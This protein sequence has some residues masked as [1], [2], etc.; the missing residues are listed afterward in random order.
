[1]PS[2]CR[3]IDDV[4]FSSKR[5]RIHKKEGEK[6]LGAFVRWIEDEANGWC[7]AGLCL[8]GK[9]RGHIKG[10]SVRLLEETDEFVEVSFST[11]VYCSCNNED[12]TLVEEPTSTSGENSGSP[13]T[14]PPTTPSACTPAQEDA[15]M[16]QMLQYYALA[17]NN[18]RA[19]G[20]QAASD[21]GYSDPGIGFHKV[22][23][24]ADWQMVSWGAIVTR[25][26]KCW[27]I[28]K[29]RARKH[30]TALTF[31]HF[32]K[33]KALKSSRVFYLDPWQTGAPDHW[34]AATFPFSSGWAHTTTHT[35]NA[36][37]A[38]RDPGND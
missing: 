5:L 11:T 1:M 12:G 36:G 29:I 19:T 28:E 20:Y 14:A 13:V 8:E 26:W 24:C 16:R 38:G 4:A 17:V 10:T 7:S 27:K 21:P 6:G 3:E 22:G 37:D 9:C 2:L 34:P 18:A 15:E 25:T 35:H 30:W 32:V 31:H 23:N 33:I